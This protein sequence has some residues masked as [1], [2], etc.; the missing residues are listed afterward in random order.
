MGILAI[1]VDHFKSINDTYGHPAADKVLK[2]MSARLRSCVYRATDTVARIGGDEFTIILSDVKDIKT[3]EKLA[4]KILR[5]MSAPIVIDGHE[6][7][8]G[9]SIGIASF[10][11]DGADPEEVKSAADNALY[12]AKRSGRNTYAIFAQEKKPNLKVVR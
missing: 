5:L 9:I 8:V 6:I 4:G 11:R 3:Y 2:M 1:D 12:D 7:S 10:P